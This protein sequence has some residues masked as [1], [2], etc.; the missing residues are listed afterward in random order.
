MIFRYYRYYIQYISLDY[1]KKTV[2]YKVQRTV[3]KRK[4]G[5]YIFFSIFQQTLEER[6][7]SLNL[8]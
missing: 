3:F 8:H 1:N 2:T 6:T 5:R 4:R 7:T